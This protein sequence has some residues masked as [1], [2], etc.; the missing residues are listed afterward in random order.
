MSELETKLYW[1]AIVPDQLGLVPNIYILLVF[2]VISTSEHSISFPHFIFL[3]MSERFPVT[4]D[5]YISVGF[6][7]PNRDQS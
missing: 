3:Y 1:G 4:V 7:A 5:S 6:V 2:R